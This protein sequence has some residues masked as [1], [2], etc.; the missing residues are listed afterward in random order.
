MK[1]IQSSVH[2]N[3]NIYRFRYASLADISSDEDCRCHRRLCQHGALGEGVADAEH[4]VPDARVH[5]EVFGRRT[6]SAETRCHLARVWTD[7][8]R[9]YSVLFLAANE[10][11][12]VLRR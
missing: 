5:N 9:A 3:P 2:N 4:S 8:G 6:G 1:A 11:L 12:G 7:T 10:M